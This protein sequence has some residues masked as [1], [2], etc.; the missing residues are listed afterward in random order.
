VP[1]GDHAA[2]AEAIDAHADA[3]L[4]RRA[5]EAGRRR[6]AQ[7]FTASGSAPVVLAAARRAAEEASQGTVPAAP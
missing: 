1:P 4:R 2:L 3:D 6:V 7:D 5:G